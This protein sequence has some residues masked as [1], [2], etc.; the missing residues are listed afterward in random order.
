MGVEREDGSEYTAANGYS[1]RKV[2][3]NWRLIH[4]IIAEEMLGR[5][6][7]SEDRIRFK[8]GNRANLEP[9]NILVSEKKTSKV[10]RI[11]YLRTK[12]ALYQEELDE[13]T[14]QD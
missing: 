7:T 9:D 10:K 5:P 3:G 4:H 14:S 2:D 1:Y 13:L 8:D 12:I 11:H 6:L